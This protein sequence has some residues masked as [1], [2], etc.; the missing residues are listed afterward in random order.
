MAVKSSS[1]LCN[2]ADSVAWNEDE[3]ALLIVTFKW[4]GGPENKTVHDGSVGK[5]LITVRYYGR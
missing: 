4:I 1:D 3:A 2:N 5:P